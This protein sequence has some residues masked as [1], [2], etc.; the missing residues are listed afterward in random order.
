MSFLRKSIVIIFTIALSLTA[1]GKEIPAQVPTSEPESTMAALETEVVLPTQTADA[2]PVGTSTAIPEENIYADCGPGGLIDVGYYFKDSSGNISPTQLVR[3]QKTSDEVRDYV[4]V[5]SCLKH[6]QGWISNPDDIQSG[7]EN[8]IIFFDKN[9]H[10]HTYRIIIGGHYV[11]PHNPNHKD[12][13]GSSNGIDSLFYTVQEWIDA[14]RQHFVLN[15]SRQIGVD[16]YL[17]DTHGALSRA[18]TK[19]YSFR[20]TNLQI[21]EALRTG[22]GYPEQVPDGFFVFATNAWLIQEE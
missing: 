21:A 1:C 3:F 17:D 11:A 13:T 8:E 10:A 12:I 2:S 20:E 5:I 19:V 18:L 9:S 7:Y 4:A 16:I 22:E 14:T 6:D 15:G